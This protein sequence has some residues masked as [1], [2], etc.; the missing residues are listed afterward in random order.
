MK[1]IKE[2][3]KK[4]FVRNY[5]WTSI[6]LFAKNIF[7]FALYFISAFFITKEEFGILNYWMSILTIFLLF[8][9]FGVSYAVLKQASELK[10]KNKAHLSKIISTM[11]LY[12]LCTGM[13][14]V[15]CV[16]LFKFMFNSEIY[17]YLKY[18]IPIFFMLPILETYNAFLKGILKFK[19]LS[20]ITLVNSLLGL[21]FSFILIQQFGLL[22]VIYSYI[23]FYI[24]QFIFLTIAIS[25]YITFS[26][27]FKILKEN[28]IYGSYIGLDSLA[29]LLFVK[30]DVFILGYYSYFEYIGMYELIN[31]I[32][33]LSVIPFGIAGLM[34]FSYV[35]KYHILNQNRKIKS[36][37]PQVVKFTF[38]VIISF[39]FIQ[40][41]IVP[42]LINLFFGKYSNSQTLTLF[43]IFLF[44]VFPIKAMKRVI[45]PG[46]LFS[47]GKI[48]IN[49]F[50]NI[51]FGL[52]NLL[53]D[54]YFIINFNFYG[55]VLST[56][57]TYIGSV[58][59]SYY[60]FSKKF[61]F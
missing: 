22:G 13:I 18:Y 60:I 61:S 6:Q 1:L 7:L 28:L 42:E 45:D 52:I 9:N 33:E 48:W 30:L 23:L 21:G 27:D 59:F 54:I 11:A 3:I 35:N 58:C 12:F 31:K 44:L 34:I 50:G 15:V 57:F 40:Y 41:L 4:S 29:V 47:T 2:F 36:L 25:E 24:L 38:L 10:R 19:Y 14:V 37:L 5:I 16:Y 8:C 55:I 49:I 32:S 53:L 17:P 20:L 56:V 51:I 46:F 43:F 39:I 26:F